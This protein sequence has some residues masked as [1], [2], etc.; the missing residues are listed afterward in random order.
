MNSFQSL[1][2]CDVWSVSEDR[3]AYVLLCSRE[4]GRLC[5]SLEIGHVGEVGRGDKSCRAIQASLSD[6]LRRMRTS[7]V[8]KR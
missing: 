5:V 8:V 7:H 3:S 6:V 4:G 1:S 2:D